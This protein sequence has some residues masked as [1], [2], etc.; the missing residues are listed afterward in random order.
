VRKF[1]TRFA[2]VCAL[3][4][5]VLANGSAI[6]SA[7]TLTYG[8]P[9]PEQAL[10]NREGVIPFLNSISEATD[11][12]VE[13]RG[14]FGGTIVKMPTV[15]SSV[16]DGVVN[17]GFVVFVFYGA[18]LPIASLMA[19]TTAFGTDPVASMGALNE[20]FYVACPECLKDMKKNGQIPLFINSTTPIRMQCTSE[21]TSPADLEGKRVSVIGP[22]EAR[23]AEALGM[24]PVRTKISDLLVSLQLGKADCAL[25]PV[26]W[27]K[28]Y[29]LLD[30]V[31]GVVDMPQGIPGGAV[32]VSLSLAAWEKISAEDKQAIV[33]TIA[34][35]VLPYVQNAYV[36]ADNGVRPE[37]EKVAHFVQ[38]DDEMK[39][40]WNAYQKAEI[41]EFAKLSAERGVEDAEA[42]A[43]N[44][45]AIYRKWHEVHLPKIIENPDMM[46]EILMETVFSKVDF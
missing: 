4:S 25:V 29:G 39:K 12:R 41:E 36:N 33:K 26:S 34:G 9:V 23:W 35:S 13:F 42:F 11:G 5:S 45:A 15:L 28:T 3:S 22:P 2:A 6:T 32:P 40:K 27:A 18:E 24:S 8:S 46:E 30:V 31:K 20:A 1:I 44:V 7:E 38:P 43:E 37:L 16:R 14:L 21:V 17:S 10:F 19:S